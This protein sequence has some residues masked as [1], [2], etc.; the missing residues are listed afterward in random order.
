M[1]CTLELAQAAFGCFAVPIIAVS[2]SAHTEEIAPKAHFTFARPTSFVSCR[3][4]DSSLWHLSHSP[5]VL[6]TLIDCVKY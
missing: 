4:G 1:L 3:S 6:M 5:T 2:I